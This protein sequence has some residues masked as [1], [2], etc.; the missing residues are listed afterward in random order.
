MGRTEFDSPDVD[1]TVLVSAENNY[2]SIGDFIEVK[3]TSA[4]D[5]DLIGELL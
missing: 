5:Y 4:E 2:I 3:I 1:N